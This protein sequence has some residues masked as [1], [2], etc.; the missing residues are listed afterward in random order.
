[1]QFTGRG[2]MMNVH[3]TD[4]PIHSPEDVKA[5]DHDLRELFYFDM[6]QAGIWMAP[7]GMLTVSLPIGDEAEARLVHGV[8]TFVEKRA[9]YL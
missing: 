3:M 8:Q 6:T 1:M 7:R 9:D 4:L 2:S 5:Q